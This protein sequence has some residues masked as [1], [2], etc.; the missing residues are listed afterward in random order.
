ML[1]NVVNF[2]NCIKT[3]YPVMESCP[4]HCRI[5]EDR[6]LVEGEER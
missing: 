1:A 5:P 6:I 4:R 2:D 3:G